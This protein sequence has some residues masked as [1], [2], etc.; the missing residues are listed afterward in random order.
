[1]FMWV[2]EKCSAYEIWLN[3]FAKGGKKGGKKGYRGK[4]KV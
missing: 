4:E 2:R 3:H 1:M